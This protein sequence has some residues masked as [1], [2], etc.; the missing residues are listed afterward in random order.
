M[1]FDEQGLVSVSDTSTIDVVGNVEM[2]LAFKI[3]DLKYCDTLDFSLNEDLPENNYFDRLDFY[4]DND[5]KIKVNL[6]LQVLFLDENDQVT[7][8]LFDAHHTINYNDPGTIVSIVTNEKID[9][10]MSS[11][12]IVMKIGL[13]TDEISEEPVQ[14][15]ITDR[16]ALRVRLLTH[17][18]EISLE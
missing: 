18:S 7:D 1:L 10:I 13:S 17:S 2:P 5:S 14:F 9:H 12:Q 11:S 16:L 3:T 15:Y 8:S 4:I 6:N